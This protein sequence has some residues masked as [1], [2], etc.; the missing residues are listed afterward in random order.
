MG[1]PDA[2]HL[3]SAQILGLAIASVALMTAM[4]PDV[5][6]Q[7]EK[8]A[9]ADKA[10][11]LSGVVLLNRYKCDDG[12]TL[13]SSR[14]TQ[15]AHLIDI[16]GRE[17]H[18]WSYPQG[19]GHSWHYAEMQPNGHLI[20]MPKDKMILELDWDSNLVWKSELSAHHDFY[21]Y[22]NGNT[23]VLS[24][25]KVTN[26]QLRPDKESYNS[27]VFVELTPDNEVVWEWYLNEHVIEMAELISDQHDILQGFSGLHTNSVEVLPD[28]PAARKDVRFK[29]GNVLFSCKKANTIGV[30]D[31]ASGKVVWAWWVGPGSAQHMPTMLPN[32]HI[33]LYDNNGH[34]EEPEH[35]RIIELDPITKRIVWEYWGDPLGRTCRHGEGIPGR[36]SSQEV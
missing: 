27:S 29:A 13:Y 36:V 34:D 12:Y 9:A 32:G 31:K 19:D 30:L 15:M 17:V 10:P 11:D 26:K 20:A 2:V 1:T 18:R 35:T 5:S 28:G 14:M 21:R 24:R 33:L 4:L 22:P 3:R 25:E 6:A 8:K 23:I 7:D 16:R